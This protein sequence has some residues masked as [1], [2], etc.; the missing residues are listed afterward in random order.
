M[1]ISV[2]CR[3]FG[4]EV[5]WH[6][7]VAMGATFEE[8]NETITHHIVDRPKMEK[9]FINRSVFNLT[10]PS[11]ITKYYYPNIIHYQGMQLVGS[12]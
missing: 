10:E 9:Q 8:N 12:Y 1:Y 2:L 7:T 6:K 11:I 3:A 5:S 4:G